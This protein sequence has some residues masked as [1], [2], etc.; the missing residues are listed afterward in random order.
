[1][2]TAPPTEPSAVTP[3]PQVV[4]APAP[5]LSEP[6]RILIPPRDTKES[7]RLVSLDAYRGFIMLAMVSG[8]FAF[9]A[10][11][12][13]FPDSGWWQFLGH[14]FEHVEWAGCSFWDLIQPSFMFMVGVAMPYSHAS[15][16]AKGAPTWKIAGHTLYRAVLLV[17]LGVFLSSNGERQTHFS[18]VNV[19]AQIGLGYAFVYLLIGRRLLQL[20]A[21]AAILVGYW[22]FF[23]LHPLPG[24]NF[25]Y[26]HHGVYG[27]EQWDGGLFAH[28]NKNANAASAFDQWFLNL[29]PRRFAATPDLSLEMSLLAPPHGPAAALPFALSKP[30]LG[31]AFYFNNG[32]YATLNFIPSMVTMIL[33]LLAGELLRSNDL[34]PLQ[35][36]LRLIFAG[37]LCGMLGALAGELVCPLVKRIWTPSWALYSAGWTF[38]MLAGFYGVIDL[39]GYRRWSWPLVV[40]GMNSIAVYLMAQL[41]KPWVRDT[42]RCHLGQDLFNR[43]GGSVY[44]P[45]A[46]SVAFLL[47]VWLAAAWMH[48]QK[49]FVRI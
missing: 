44:A 16:K 39:L 1:M 36:L 11:A 49:I 8:G 38:C 13:K 6:L 3:E 21:I 31:H 26:L 7:T 23:Y 10:V 37:L 47:V 18:F 4:A 20:G 41:L 43:F 25:N 15:R 19:L 34:D 42:L 33:G 28:W 12:K 40:V 30:E 45:I 5:P 27:P 24:P 17:A 46:Q 22:L 14:Q 35:K 29:F 32:G 9:H 48:R 2:S